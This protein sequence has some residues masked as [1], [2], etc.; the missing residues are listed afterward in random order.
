MVLGQE[1]KAR[2]EALK[3]SQTDLARL[4]GV[5][6]PVINDLESGKQRTTKRIAAIAAAL[7][8]SI[9]DIDPE[10][11]KVESLQSPKINFGSRD[12]PVYASVEGAPAANQSSGTPARPLTAR[13]RPALKP[14][15]RQQLVSSK[16]PP[17][18]RILNKNGQFEKY[19]FPYRFAYCAFL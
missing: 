7:N 11:E 13:I 19:L 3:L 17:T 14:K 9:S 15:P 10:F 4:A 2:R 8:C 1:I 18:A 16:A 5:S 6:Q 12:L